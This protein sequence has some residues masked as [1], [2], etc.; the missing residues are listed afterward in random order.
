MWF[1]GRRR[2]AVWRSTYHEKRLSR[3]VKN[4]FSKQRSD[5]AVE[6]HRALI[7]DEE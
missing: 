1:A 5:V 6:Q 3:L 4:D 7:K 2:R